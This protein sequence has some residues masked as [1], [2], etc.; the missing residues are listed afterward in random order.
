MLIRTR[1]AV[2]LLSVLAT[3]SCTSSDAKPEATPTAKPNQM[4]IA[5][6]E[7]RRGSVTLYRVSQ[8]RRAQKLRT[9]SAAPGYEYVTAIQMTQDEDPLTCI[10]HSGTTA[11][12]DTRLQTR[13]YPPGD[14]EGYE[15][16]LGQRFLGLARDG[17]RLLSLS[18]MGIGAP[19]PPRHLYLSRLHDRTSTP[20]SSTEV[21]QAPEP[22]SDVWGLAWAG[23]GD[24]VLE[25]AAVAEDPPHTVVQSVEAIF[26]GQEPGTGTVLRPRGPLAKG[27][28]WFGHVKPLDKDTG[29]ARMFFDIPCHEG[30]PCPSHAPWPEPKAVRLDLHTGEVLEIVAVAAKGRSLG[31]LSGGTHGIVYQTDEGGQNK[32]VYVRWPGEKHGTRVSGLPTGFSE[33]VAQH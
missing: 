10:V 14:A 15:L 8:D 32:W 29:L 23:D 16:P 6:A 20:V 4:V 2:A 9:I 1:L 27:Y 13:C 33:V 7:W 22:C 24:V 28:D 25:C 3:F 11:D 12:Y 31:D 18:D 5:I 26:A 30:D 19:P 21:K 17:S